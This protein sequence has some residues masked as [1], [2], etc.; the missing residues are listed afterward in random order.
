MGTGGEHHD[1]VPTTFSSW[2]DDM[3]GTGSLSVFGQRSAIYNDIGLVIVVT[4]NFSDSISLS[5]GYL[6]TYANKS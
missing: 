5:A 2:D 6:A 3:G 4:Y 1:D